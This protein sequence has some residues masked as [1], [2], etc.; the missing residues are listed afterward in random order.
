MVTNNQ[1]PD[2]LGRIKVKIPLLSGE[3]EANWA[4]VAVL[5]AG[6]ARG[7]FF[8]PEVNDEVLVAFELGDINR[9]YI[10]G[11]L[12]NGVDKPPLSN[13]DGKNNQRE[14]KSR[15][16]HIIR[17]DD[18]DGQEKLTIMDKSGNN[19]IEFDTKNNSVLI[20]SAK[21]ITLSAKNGKISLEG[22]KIE[23]VA[24]GELNL[25]AS[26]NTTVKGATINLN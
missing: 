21:D 2:G 18:T 20:K 26:G 22:G 7:T 9:P 24:T 12:W 5:M 14:I 6:K 1:D 23:V 16:G 4:R 3:D 13:G 17:F 8:L 25:K 11:A 10:I 19:Q 15:S